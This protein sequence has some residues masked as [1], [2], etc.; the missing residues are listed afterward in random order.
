MR[1]YLIYLLELAEY[2][3]V[4]GR[5]ADNLQDGHP[6]GE[7]LAEGQVIRDI[8]LLDIGRQRTVAASAVSVA[9]DQLV[10]FDRIDVSFNN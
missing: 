6:K 1:F 4:F 10:Q 7:L 8:V 9:F 3:G 2:V 5:Y